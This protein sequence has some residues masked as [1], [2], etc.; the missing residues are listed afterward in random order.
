MST[1]RIFRLTNYCVVEYITPDPNEVQVPISADFT[2]FHNK[3]TGDVQFFNSNSDSTGNIQDYTVTKTDGNTYVN[4]DVDKVPNFLDY[5]DNL[6]YTEPS[7]DPF[8]Y[9]TIRFHFISGFRF[10][11]FEALIFT[12]KN[13][14]NNGEDGIFLSHL[15][16]SLIMQDVIV[17]NP[18]PIFLTDA[19]FDRY[20][21]VKIPSIKQVNADYYSA[22]DASTTLGARISPRLNS[23]EDGFDG[24][25]GYVTDFPINISLSESNTYTAFTP[26]STTYDT[27]V[28]NDHYDLS[29]V[30]TNDYDGISAEIHESE[31]GNFIEYS[32]MKYNAFPNE[33]IA[34]LNSKNPHNNWIIIHEIRVYE[35]VGSSQIMTNNSM[36]YQY[37]NFEEFLN[38]R[39]VLKYADTSVAF[40]LDYTVR[41]TNAYD[42]EQVIR[43]GAITLY[44][45]KSYG[46]DTRSLIADIT[47][48]PYKVYN[49]I[50]VKYGLDKSN[51]Y[52][53]PVFNDVPNAPESET[54]EI[55]YITKYEPYIV[56]F[57]KVGL[58]SHSAYNRKVSSDS[59]VYGQGKHPLVISPM[60]N[61]FKFIIH[62]Q[63]DDGIYRP[64]DMNMAKKYKLVFRT[65]GKEIEIKTKSEVVTEKKSVSEL[66]I[67]RIQDYVP[68]LESSAT[69]SDLDIR[70]TATVDSF[71]AAKGVESISDGISE[72][73]DAKNGELVFKLNKK[74]AQVL[75]KSKTDEFFITMLTEDGTETVLYRGRWYKM[76][77]DD[78][79]K[80]KEIDARL[81]PI[82]VKI[83]KDIDKTATTDISTK[84]SISTVK[85]NTG[86]NIAAS[87]DS[88]TNTVTGDDP[89]I[90]V[91]GYSTTHDE[92]DNVPLI[93]KITPRQIL[94]EGEESV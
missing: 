37:E 86:A 8:Q 54:A 93:T 49:K 22:P 92:N 16:N 14:M 13:Q 1:G 71:D 94:K 47:A 81:D 45:P 57:I 27:Y 10:D 87:Y 80:K 85:V 35:H 2:V 31:E 9:D 4:L 70:K 42:G 44:N 62:E 90:D 15:L 34:Y 88:T 78:S 51:M 72:L 65:G 6:I 79:V 61:I 26:D 18:H 7:T 30:Q 38:Y 46:K 83:S 21:E 19:F 5:D 12:I 50:S 68:P 84:N 48:Q 20:F 41:L 63:D 75:Y 3:Y 36:F 29:I 32:L 17:L 91:P 56:N 59:F 23:D 40:S 52:T 77:D 33:F 67:E 64:M 28:I 11:E 66:R 89:D 43:T 74:D 73:S 24:Y 53:E 39:P 25:I 82:D 76:S 58:S 69:R 60:D 55:Q